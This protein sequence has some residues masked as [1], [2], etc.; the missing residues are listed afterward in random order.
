[1]KESKG[2]RGILQRMERR[3]KQKGKM[4]EWMDR[5]IREKLLKKRG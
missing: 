1:M 2:V 3:K 5:L 4:E